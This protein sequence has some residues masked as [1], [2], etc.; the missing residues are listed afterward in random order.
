MA[1]S[2]KR[3]IVTSALPYINGI[4]HLGNLVGSLLPA[5][6]YTRYLKLQGNEVIYICGT[7]DH[8]TPAELSAHE[9]GKPVDEYCKEM[10]LVQRDIYERFGLKFDYFGRT[11]DIENHEIT[12][13]LFLGLYENGYI[14]E[15]SSTQLYSIDDER[16]LPDRYVIGTCPHCGYERARGDQCESCTTLLDPA[17]LVN[18]RSSISGST[19]LEKREV[20][21]FYI[22]LTKLEPQIREWIDGQTEWPTT[23]ISIAKKWLTEGLQ[24]RSI[25]RNLDWGIEIPLEGHDDKVFYVWFDA[26]IGYISITKHWA[27]KIIK[28]P[29]LF[30]KYWKDPNTR[31]YQFLGSDN[32]PFH[33]IFFPGTIMGYNE[34]KD[35]KDRY[36]LTNYI[37]GFQWL[38]YESGKFSTSQNRGVFTDEALNLYPADYWRYYLTLISPERQNTDFKWEGFQVA[39]NA[40]LNNLL[41]NLVNRYSTFIHKH[42]ESTIPSAIIGKHEK[43]LQKSLKSTLKEYKATFDKVEFQ[44]PLKALKSFWADCNKYFQDKAPWASVKDEATFEDAAT[45]AS[46]LAHAL[47]S[48]AI[49]AAPFIPFTAEQIFERLGLE[50][51]DAHSVDWKE[52][53]DWEILTGTTVPE[54]KGNLFTKVSDK[55]VKNLKAQYG[56]SDKETKES[57]KEEKPKKKKSPKAKPDKSTKPQK[58]E[59]EKEEGTTDQIE[60]DEFAKV[61]LIAVKI[62]KAEDHPNADKLV[63]LTV[64]DG[65]RKDRTIVAGIRKS[66]KDEE[67]VG[68]TIIIVDNLKPAKLRGIVSEG[69]L[70][71]AE[72]ENT[73]S[74][75]NPTRDVEAG[76][77]IR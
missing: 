23:S 39:V 34:N 68:K 54:I 56:S 65:K 50:P 14:T 27:D 61:K 36:N 15:K 18:P 47:R 21:H 41:G 19:N 70:L 25:T 59:N 32:V 16:Y 67:L 6:I 69:M 17:D 53:E 30:K 43:I 45:T 64:D 2:A 63:V 58:K 38:T 75:L 13:D 8:G 33:A 49:L 1:K 7:D 73:I 57:S 31:Y 28:K 10:Y 42:F 71:A 22:N 55:E 62:L 72:D 3:I 60:Y 66:Y 77:K 12:Q 24:E 46:T 48:I 11:H 40:D 9:A 35:P 76:S 29:S 52:V 4:K 44:K 37:K 5:D 74:V 51:S 26:P 20:N